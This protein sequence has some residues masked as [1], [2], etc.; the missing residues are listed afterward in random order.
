M[1]QYLL[2]RPLW[3]CV[4]DWHHSVERGYFPICSRDHN[5]PSCLYVR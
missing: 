1:V 2:Q 4:G 3:L 5:W